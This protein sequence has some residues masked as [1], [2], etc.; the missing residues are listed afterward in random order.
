MAAIKFNRMFVQSFVLGLV[1]I[2]LFVAKCRLVRSSPLPLLLGNVS[3]PVEVAIGNWKGIVTMRSAY[4]R[5]QTLLRALPDIGKRVKLPAPKGELSVENVM[6]RG[7]GVSSS[8][9]KA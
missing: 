1:R 3:N 6:V 9:S 8:F 2:S 4:D 7:P 5:V